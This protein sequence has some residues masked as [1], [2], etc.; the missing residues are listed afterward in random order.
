MQTYGGMQF[1]TLSTRILGRFVGSMRGM[2][3]CHYML[4]YNVKT[5]NVGGSPRLD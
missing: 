3:G 1:R 5:Y 4:T 2:K